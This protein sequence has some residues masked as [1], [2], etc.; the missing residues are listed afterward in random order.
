M[1]GNEQSYGG[2]ADCR[3]RLHLH[4]WLAIYRKNREIAQRFTDTTQRS[5]ALEPAKTTLVG[6]I[7]ALLHVW[8][9]LFPA[10]VIPVGVLLNF[11]F[12]GLAVSDPDA[13]SRRAMNSVLVSVAAICVVVLAT[14]TALTVTYKKHPFLKILTT[15]SATGYAFPGAVLAIGVVSFSGALDGLFA[16]AA[17]RR[18][19]PFIRWISDRRLG[20]HPRLRDPFSGGWTG[21]ARVWT[22]CPQCYE[23]KFCS[24]T[25]FSS[26]ADVRTPTAAQLDDGGRIAGI[27]GC[28]KELPDLLLRPFN[29]DTL[30]T[31][32]Y[33]RERRIAGRS[34]S[35][36]ARTVAVLSWPGHSDERVPETANWK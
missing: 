30:S 5:R 32:V 20:Y 24:G 2:G 10:L 12:Q 15:V 28:H 9:R 18:L 31:Y 23:R 19:W 7:F 34:G 1:A 33:R 11:I 21:V 25:R 29:F 16:A 26:S 4:Y 3:Y 17:A 35:R 22:D 27:R 6:G 8:R 36:R 14:V 13:L